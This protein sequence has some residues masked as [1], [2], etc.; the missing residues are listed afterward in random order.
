M[1]K[2]LFILLV[3]CFILMS[4][5]GCANGGAAVDGADIAVVGADI[6][7]ADAG[8]AEEKH[9][10][11]S[12]TTN[13]MIDIDLTELSAT[14]VYA[15]VNSIMTN[16]DDYIGKT[17]KMKGPYYTSFFDET[18]LY[19]HYVI[20]EDATACC[21]QGLEFIWNGEHAYPDDYPNEESRIEVAGVFGSYDE[22][23]KTYYYLAVDDVFIAD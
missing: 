9:N 19:Y 16:P 2:V 13:K 7:A 6:A 23:G 5:T 14:M 15:E 1:K 22:L 12:N 10:S 18:N 20:I 11:L 21:A 3:S 4:A 8:I 17:I